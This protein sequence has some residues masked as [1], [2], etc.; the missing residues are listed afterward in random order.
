MSSSSASRLSTIWRSLRSLTAA[1]LGSQSDGPLRES[2]RARPRPWSPA[3]AARSTAPP[4][5]RARACP[6]RRSAPFTTQPTNGT[7]PIAF[8]A[9]A[10]KPKPDPIT[11]EHLR[12]AA[13]GRS[14]SR[15]RRRSAARAGPGSAVR[16]GRSAPG[17][18]TATPMTRVLAR[19]LPDQLLAHRF[20]QHGQAG[21]ERRRRLA[22][23][24]CEPPARS[25]RPGSPR[26]RRRAR[27]SRRGRRGRGRRV[28]RRGTTATTGRPRR[29]P[30]RWSRRSSSSVGGAGEDVARAPAAPFDRSLLAH[31]GGDAAAGELL[32][33]DGNERRGPGDDERPVLAARTSAGPGR[34]RHQRRRRRPSPDRF[35]FTSGRAARVRG[36]ARGSPGARRSRAGSRSST[37]RRR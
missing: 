2:V 34:R 11:R 4:P 25:R 29:A 8:R 16:I 3:R 13:P 24:A 9:S 32:D 37:S 21:G 27:R 30:P 14:R 20:A 23:R 10:R 19:E 22:E 33:E 18:K 36:R 26:R 31:R 15:A 17:T 28:R 35:V 6:R 1:M 12:E 7:Y 5:R